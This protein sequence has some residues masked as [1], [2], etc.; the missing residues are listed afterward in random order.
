MLRAELDVTRQGYA[1]WRRRQGEP[2]TRQVADVDL[3][4]VIRDVYDGTRGRYGSPWV[5]RELHSHG[6]RLGRH[7]VA[8]SWPPMG[9]SG[10]P[11]VGPPTSKSQQFRKADIVLSPP[12]PWPN[13]DVSLGKG[14]A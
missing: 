11:A 13:G 7:R 2:T 5:H 1:A 4:D 12:A 6:Y 14:G 10:G 9:W 8:A 3:L